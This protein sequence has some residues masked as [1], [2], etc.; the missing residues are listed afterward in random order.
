MNTIT[1]FIARHPGAADAIHGAIA[2]GSFSPALP[3]FL[4]DVER[5][6]LYNVLRTAFYTRAARR[7]A[8]RR[9]ERTLASR[10]EALGFRAWREMGCYRGEDR[11][12]E[13]TRRTALE[14][15]CWALRSRRTGE[16]MPPARC[17]PMRWTA[18]P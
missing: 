5:L 13:Y 2:T 12:A 6:R 4:D 18:A 15:A 7:W 11:S 1:D 8:A 10:A 3:V 16:P 17:L 9:E 14:V